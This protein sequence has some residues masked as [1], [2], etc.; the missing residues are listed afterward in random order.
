MCVCLSVCSSVPVPAGKIPAELSQGM[1]TAEWA[2]GDDFGE[3]VG[4]WVI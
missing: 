2:K 4:G 3:S 1:C